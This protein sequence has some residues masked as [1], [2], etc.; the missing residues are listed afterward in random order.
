VFFIVIPLAVVALF[1]AMRNV[2][3]H[4]NEG[5]EPVDNL[6]GILSCCWS[7]RSCS[8][9]TSSRWATCGRRRSGCW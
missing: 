5:T 8:R 9:S 1:L 3:S 2:P 6:G 4:V 7:A